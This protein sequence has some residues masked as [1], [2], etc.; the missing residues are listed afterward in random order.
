MDRMERLWAL[1]SLWAAAKEVYPYFDR[2]ETDWDETYRAYIPRLLAAGEGLESWLLLCEFVRVLNDGHSTVILPQAY[3]EANGSTPFRFTQVGN[4]FLVTAAADERQLLREA[5]T[6]D[7]IPM[8]Q[9]VKRLD[10]YKYTASGHPYGGHLEGWL[11]LLLPGRDHVLSTD[12]GEMPFSFPDQCPPL[13]KAP[14]PESRRSFRTVGEGMRLFDDGV[15]CARVDDMQHVDRAAAFQKVLGRVRP[16]AVIFDIRRNMGGMTLCGARYAQPFFEGRFGGSRK[17]T[18]SRRAVDAASNSQLSCMGPASRQRLLDEGIL[19]AEDYSE[20]DRYTRRLQ[21]ECYNDSWQEACETKLIDCPVLLLTSR[22]TISAAEDFTC[23]FKDNRRGR[24]MGERT[25]GS[26]GSPYLLRLP[27]GGRGQVV[28]VGY[29]MADGTP[30]IGCGIQ[31][32]I[33]CP[34]TVEDWRLGW[35]RQLDL[36]L[37]HLA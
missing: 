15:L 32:D 22:D 23:F 4:R 11:P 14:E 30:F 21:F 27:E 26:T 31:P 8:E 37:E 18:Q 16:R 3:R 28:S 36:A 33:P 7:G 12:G 34:P 1:S 10:R 25:F 2:L 17:W 29:E 24:V 9:L 13:L 35:D 19:K 5:L 20:A 6:I